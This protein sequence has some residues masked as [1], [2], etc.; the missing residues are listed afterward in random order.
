MS[1]SSLAERAVRETLE[2]AF[3][4]KKEQGMLVISDEDSPLARVLADAYHVVVPQARFMTFAVGQ[5]EETLAALNACVRNQLVVLIQSA[6]F[7]LNEFR[8]RIELFK[9]GIQ[10]IEYVH[11]G[12]MPEEQYEIYLQALQYDKDFYHT[13]GP[14]IKTRLDAARAIQ[15][16]CEDTV[17]NYQSPME[18]SKLNI[19]DYTGMENVGGTYPI[20]EVFSEPRDLT[21]VNGEVRI[22]GFAGMD[23]R[24][25]FYEPFKAIIEKGIMTAGPD[26]P[27]EFLDTLDLIRADEDVTVREF[28]LGLNRAMGKHTLLSDV[29]A[30]ERQLGLH[31]SL[32]GKHTI[33]KKEGLNRKHMR[34]HVDIFIDVNRI[35]VDDTVLFENG[36]FVVA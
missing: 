10:N 7:R 21:A 18:D 6:N 13:M 11:L 24:V 15:V 2:H 17:L 27:Q 16:E 22:F 34:Y 19:G 26:A 25:R 14:A 33:Y 36:S 32:G 31:M 28:G 3:H 5:E 35:L 9:K 4:W 23:H 20:G 1:L 29:T 12:R 30:F 8:I